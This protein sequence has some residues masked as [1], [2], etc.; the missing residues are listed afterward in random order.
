M[1]TRKGVI[2]VTRENLAVAANF[3]TEKLE[4]REIEDAP[5]IARWDSETNQPVVRQRYAKEAHDDI[6]DE[7]A[8][9]KGTVGYRYVN[10]DGDEVPNER[11][12]YVQLTPEG[13]AEEVEKRPSSVLTGEVVPVEKWVDRDAVDTFLVESTYEVWG[14][15]AADEAALQELAEYV[16]EAGET[17]MF[18]WMLQPEFYKT[19]GLLVPQF[20]EDADEFSLFVKTTRKRLEPNHE[21]PVL[22]QS[23]IEEIE[24]AAEEHFVEQEV[25]G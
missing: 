21:M 3:E 13:D 19:W 23:E 25:P 1:A 5:E 10:E 18:V 17:P 12:T 24:A 2:Q 4:A 22:S 8:L 16:E 20:D 15:E 9:P 14:Q 7:P 6:E 11:L